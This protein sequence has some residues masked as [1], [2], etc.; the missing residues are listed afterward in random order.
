MASADKLSRSAGTIVQGRLIAA[1]SIGLLMASAGSATEPPVVVEYRSAFAEYRH[2]DAQAPAVEWRTANDAI[3]DGA[4][5][6]AHGH[7]MHA[8]PATKTA[9]HPGEPE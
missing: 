7:G 8:V 5:A 6:A 2:F 3:R 4:E 1:I 9:D